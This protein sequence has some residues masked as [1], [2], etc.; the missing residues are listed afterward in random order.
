[1]KIDQG[2]EDANKDSIK[3]EVTESE[4]KEPTSIQ[5]SEKKEYTESIKQE[6]SESNQKEITDVTMK[7]ENESQSSSS[8]K[9]GVRD[10]VRPEEQCAPQ[11]WQK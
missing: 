5:P 7:D 2:L 11:E 1:M 9:E 8:V 6:V 4:I 3:K 10:A